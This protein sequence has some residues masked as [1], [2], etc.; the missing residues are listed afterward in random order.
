MQTSER[1]ENKKD[2]AAAADIFLALAAKVNNCFEEIN[3]AGES[4]MNNTVKKDMA[5]VKMM[6]ADAD[7]R[8]EK[9]LAAVFSYYE[10]LF[11]LMNTLIISDEEEFEKLEIV[12]GHFGIP[13]RIFAKELVNYDVSALRPEMEKLCRILK[14]SLL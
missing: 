1:T 12:C 7:E 3:F 9:N 11:Y 2:F 10:K 13:K 14:N 4:G 5:K 8:W 6:A